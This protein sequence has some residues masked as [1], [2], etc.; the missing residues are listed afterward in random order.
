[1][2]NPKQLRFA[3]EYP[4]DYNATQAALRAGYSPKTARSQGQRL[5]TIVDIQAKIQERQKE[6]AAAAFVTQERVV[7]ELAKIAFYDVNDYVEV[8][9]LDSVQEVHIKT[10]VPVD[11]RG[12]IA[13]IRA[14]Q[15]GIEVKLADKMRALEL[16]GKHAGMFDNRGQA[17]DPAKSNLFA[18]IKESAAALED[19]D[20]V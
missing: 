18:A 16:L 1:V 13:G 12:A 14:T 9:E 4:T 15:A 7:A 11:K 8:L 5:L 3:Q 20:A 6:L 10:A 17:G 2:L 19:D